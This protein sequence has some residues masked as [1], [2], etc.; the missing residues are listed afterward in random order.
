MRLRRPD[1][2]WEAMRLPSRPHQDS[3]VRLPLQQPHSAAEPPARRLQPAKLKLL[4]PH[5][6]FRPAPLT[7]RT[8]FS[9]SLPRPSPA[10]HTVRMRLQHHSPLVEPTL[11]RNRVAAARKF[12][13]ESPPSCWLQP[14]S[15]PP[16][17]TSR[18]AP[19]SPAAARPPAC[20]PLSPPR[21]RP[22]R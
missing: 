2:C 7:K 3:P 6:L 4:T 9:R 22:S 1:R 8:L 21:K 13:W 17:H 16:G 15:T 10:S 5:Q 20:Q 11:L 19:V 12:S 14:D 18:V